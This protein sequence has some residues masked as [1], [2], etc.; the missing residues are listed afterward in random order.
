M[1]LMRFT[2]RAYVNYTEEDVR[3]SVNSAVRLTFSNSHF[4]PQLGS[5]LYNR[6]LDVEG[7]SGMGHLCAC[8]GF[9]LNVREYAGRSAVQHP[10]SYHWLCGSCC[11]GGI[12]N[13]LQRF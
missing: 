12:A 4:D 10:G 8:T 3:N 5:Q 9:S 1:F 2:E 11:K 13:T 6:Y 7:K